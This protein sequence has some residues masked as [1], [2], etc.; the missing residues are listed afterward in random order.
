M[1]VQSD[2]VDMSPSKRRRRNENKNTFKI[3]D[4]EK[5]TTKVA[6]P[7]LL[8]VSF[9]AIIYYCTNGKVWDTRNIENI[10]Y[11]VFLRARI[12]VAYNKV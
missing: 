5:S 10:T 12:A 4:I 3:E 1:F 11:S 6:L 8:V 7:T 2:Y 9:F